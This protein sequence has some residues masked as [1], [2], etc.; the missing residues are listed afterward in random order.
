MHLPG[1]GSP[2]PAS[3][4]PRRAF[5]ELLAEF[6]AAQLAQRKATSRSSSHRAK[7]PILP[8]GYADP[9][10]A[11]RGDE[12]GYGGGVAAAGGGLRAYGGGVARV[13]EAVDPI[14]QAEWR[15]A[16]REL[17]PLPPADCDEPMRPSLVDPSAD[18]PQPLAVGH[19]M[20]RKRR[21]AAF[22]LA[23]L[24]KEALPHCIA[25][26]APLP[27]LPPTEAAT[28]MEGGDDDGGG[29]LKAAPRAANR[30]LANPD[31]AGVAP[32]TAPMSRGGRGGRGTS[33]RGRGGG[34]VD[35]GADLDLG[36]PLVPVAAGGGSLAGGGGGSSRAQQSIGHLQ[37]GPGMPR[38]SMQHQQQA[39]QQQQQQ[40]LQRQL[41]LQQ[42][43]QQQQRQ[44]QMRAGHGYG[45]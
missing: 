19:H 8:M 17:T 33:G 6:N 10:H 16:L 40:Q 34:V 3:D 27:D 15:E 12:A 42:Q 30:R 23:S 29:A 13:A 35:L 41:L 2:T 39:Q 45:L 18:W 44:Q 25:P 21:F 4:V 1:L 28:P 31:G 7:V 11:M 20:R 37:G 26:G 5:D 24:H 38:G 32:S 14:W 43:Q 22:P 9:T 36:G